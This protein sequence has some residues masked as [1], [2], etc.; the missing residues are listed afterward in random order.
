LQFLIYSGTREIIDVN[1]GQLDILN[2]TPDYADTILQVFDKTVFKDLEPLNQNALTND[3]K[4][5]IIADQMAVIFISQHPVI[6][7]DFYPGKVIGVGAN[8]SIPP[9]RVIDRV[10]TYGKRYPIVVPLIKDRL[11]GMIATYKAF[12]FVVDFGKYI[13]NYFQTKQDLKEPSRIIYM[14]SEGIVADDLG[15]DGIMFNPFSLLVVNS[16]TIFSTNVASSAIDTPL[17]DGLVD[18]Q[19]LVATDIYN[20]TLTPYSVV[21]KVSFDVVYGSSNIGK[22]RYNIWT[23][24]G[25]NYQSYI[26]ATGLTR[27]HVFNLDNAIIPRPAKRGD[28]VTL[29]IDIEDTDGNVTSFMNTIALYGYEPKP[30]L[31]DLKIYQVMPATPV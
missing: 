2:T 30:L 13:P 27:S 21:V 18:I 4:R 16:E 17:I 20:N 24:E 22:I 5:A 26:D 23:K 9:K 8:E 28:V 29:Q 25:L 7:A 1:V 10:I 12:N 31:R 14:Y 6:T 19:N 11:F 15:V 3:Q